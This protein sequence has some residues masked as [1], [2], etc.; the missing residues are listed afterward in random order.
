M[1]IFRMYDFFSTVLFPWNHR[2]YYHFVIK[3]CIIPLKP[4]NILSFCDRIMNYFLDTTERIIILWSKY[5]LFSWKRIM[6][7]PFVFNVCIIPIQPNCVTTPLIIKC[8]F[9]LVTLGMDCFYF[10]KKR[11]FHFVNDVKKIDDPSLRIKN[12]FDSKALGSEKNK[13]HFSV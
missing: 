7:Y 1:I 5:V 11:S 12:I 8:D 6:C 9:S 3:L 4:Q 2:T 13:S 10:F